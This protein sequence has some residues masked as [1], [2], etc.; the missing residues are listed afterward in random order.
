MQKKKNIYCIIK[1][2]FF[3]FDNLFSVCQTVGG[4]WSLYKSC[5]VHPPSGAERASGP[6]FDC[7]VSTWQQERAL[8]PL[9]AYT[10]ANLVSDTVV[11][12]KTV[13]QA[14]PAIGQ[15][16]ESVYINH[17]PVR[18]LTW[19][20]SNTDNITAR[21]IQLFALIDQIR[22]RLVTHTDG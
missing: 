20:P 10:T 21:A 19:L 7:L 16:Y 6:A 14:V 15:S 3:F 11:Q 4:C 22:G 9:T 13:C 18:G 1:C 17:V 8:R 2:F 5:H 12:H